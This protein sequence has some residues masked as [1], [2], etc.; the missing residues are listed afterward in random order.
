MANYEYIP[1]ARLQMAER[2]IT[3]E[4]VER[5]VGSGDLLETIANRHIR[6][7]VFRE[8]YHWQQ[9]EYRHKEVTVVYAVEPDRTV[10]I[11]AIARFGMFGEA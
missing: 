7:R 3:S 5:T 11:T 4:E 1:H 9:R 2:G 8:G 10:I 6:R